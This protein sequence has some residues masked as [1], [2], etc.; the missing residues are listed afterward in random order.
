MAPAPRG[1]VLDVVLDGLRADGRGGAV[2]DDEVVL[3][4]EG[5]V[6]VVDAGRAREAAL[7]APAG[8]AT[9]GLALA[10]VGDYAG[11]ARAVGDSLAVLGTFSV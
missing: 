9:L 1:D 4:R 11:A 3:G 7:S 6:A 10:S 5:R 8:S 2:G